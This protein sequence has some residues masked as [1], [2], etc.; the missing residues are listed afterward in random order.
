MDQK[1]PADKHLEPENLRHGLHSRR[2]LWYR[3]IMKP[4]VK[5]VK[6]ISKE[7]IAFMFIGAL[8]SG[9]CFIGW[10]VYNNLPLQMAVLKMDI[11]KTNRRI[12][13]LEEKLEDKIDSRHKE[14]QR[15]IDH[16]ED[17]LLQEIRKQP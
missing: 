17:N 12:D 8:F 6:A 13:R 2:K 9:I 3:E 1:Q 7:G 14:T 16:L 10:Q 11:K 4:L 15:R 5:A